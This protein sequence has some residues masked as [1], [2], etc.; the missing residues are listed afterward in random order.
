[1]FRK[2]DAQVVVARVVQDL[3]CFIR[4]YA[5]VAKRVPVHGASNVLGR[6]GQVLGEGAGAGQS[7][8]DGCGGDDDVATTIHDGLPCKRLGA[9]TVHAPRT[10]SESG[11]M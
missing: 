4:P 1:A 6:R 7:Q 2:R 10:A 5:A 8:C 3:V 11:A 9:A